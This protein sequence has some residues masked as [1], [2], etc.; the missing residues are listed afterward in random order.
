MVK[1]YVDFA[2]QHMNTE[3]RELLPMLLDALEDGDWEDIDAAYAQDQDPLSGAARKAD[4]DALFRE[5]VN[6]APAPM[7]FGDR[8]AKAP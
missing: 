4:F 7:G 2:R 5:I 1:A 8:R 3:E 6:L